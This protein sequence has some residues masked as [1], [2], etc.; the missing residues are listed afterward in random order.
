MLLPVRILYHG[1]DPPQAATTLSLK[2]DHC[3]RPNEIPFFKLS[4]QVSVRPVRGL[5]IP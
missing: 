1:Y 3:P 2:E 5:I 4:F